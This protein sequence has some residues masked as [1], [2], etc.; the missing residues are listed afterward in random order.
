MKER[1]QFFLVKMNPTRCE[2]QK[3]HD[4]MIKV[5]IIPT[6][7]KKYGKVLAFLEELSY[8]EQSMKRL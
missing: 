2:L 3:T 7:Q 1:F 8:N 4:L 6:K 5:L